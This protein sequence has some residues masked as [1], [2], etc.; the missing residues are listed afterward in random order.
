MN[1][2]LLDGDITTEQYVAAENKHDDEDVTLEASVTGKLEAKIERRDNRISKLKSLVVL[3]DEKI[4][5]LVCTVNNQSNKIDKLVLVNEEQSKDIKHLTKINMVV[6]SKLDRMQ[7]DIKDMSDFVKK[8]CSNEQLDNNEKECLFIYDLRSQ[9][10]Y[11]DNKIHFRLC[12]GRTYYIDNLIDSLTTKFKYY[13]EKFDDYEQYRFNNIDNAGS[14]IKLL[15]KEY[16]NC[17]K[18][19]TM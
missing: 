3:K 6:I 5:K 15:R 11:D 9:H 14:C 10:Y 8:N 7:D 12:A 4:D 17:V 19:K 2:A 13:G 18:N 1:D 16:N